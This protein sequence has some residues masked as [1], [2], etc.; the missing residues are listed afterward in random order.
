MRLLRKRRSTANQ[1]GNDNNFKKDDQT[2]CGPFRH[3]VRKP[4]KA[5]RQLEIYALE[6]QQENK[7]DKINGVLYNDSLDYASSN[8]PNF[9]S[10]AFEFNKSMLSQ[11]GSDY[12]SIDSL[13]NISD[14]NKTDK[15]DNYFDDDENQLSSS[16]NDDDQNSESRSGKSRRKNNLQCLNSRE[17]NMRRLE[18]NE[19]ERM[20]MH[21]LNDAFQ[22]LRDVI[23]HKRLERK[24]SKIET[25]TIAKNYIM[26]LADSIC[27]LRGEYLTYIYTEKKGEKLFAL[28]YS[29][30]IFLL[31]KI[32]LKTVGKNK[33]INHL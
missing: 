19:R 27:E 22:A 11:L 26:I 1:N 2:E 4:S 8:T 20:R 13:L 10:Q 9:L 31:K 30:L 12:E 24:L 3:Y 6:Q 21:S 25:L 7:D 29:F 28:L 16:L 32:N 14:E 33:F 15:I 18:S 23:P 17:R 5:A